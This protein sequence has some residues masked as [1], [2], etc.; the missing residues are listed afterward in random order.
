MVI[1]QVLEVLHCLRTDS[2][3][4]TAVVS[5]DLKRRKPRLRETK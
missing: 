5:S 1:N 3:D 4:G 2:E